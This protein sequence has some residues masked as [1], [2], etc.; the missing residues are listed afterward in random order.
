MRWHIPHPHLTH[1]QAWLIL[2][3]VFLTL[4]ACEALV[5]F[6]VVRVHEAV[7]G[8]LVI[9]TWAREWIGRALERVV[10]SLE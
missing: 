9:T 7:E 3:A 5:A 2:W 10:T 4:M 1:R 8:T 6:H